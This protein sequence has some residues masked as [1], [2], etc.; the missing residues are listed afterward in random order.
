MQ[1]STI[2]T[3][4]DFAQELEGANVDVNFW[5]KAEVHLKDGSPLNLHDLPERLNQCWKTTFKLTEEDLKSTEKIV[6]TISSLFQKAMVRKNERNYITQLFAY[7]REWTSVQHCWENDDQGGQASI[8]KQRTLTVLLPQPI[9]LGS[10]TKVKIPKAWI[11]TP[12]TEALNAYFRIKQNIYHPQPLTL[13][14][15]QAF[16]SPANVRATTTLF[17]GYN[18]ATVGIYPHCT[19]AIANL[20]KILEELW[21]QFKPESVDRDSNI[22]AA[23]KII[24]RITD[25]NRQAEAEMATRN[26]LTRKLHARKVTPWGKQEI[27]YWEKRFGI[28]R[29]ENESVVQSNIPCPPD[30]IFGHALKVLILDPHK[31]ISWKADCLMNVGK[32][33]KAWHDIAKDCELWHRLLESD[34]KLESDQKV[35]R[36]YPLIEKGLS[37]GVCQVRQRYLNIFMNLQMTKQISVRF[38]TQNTAP[39]RGLD[40]L[41][42]GENQGAYT[43]PYRSIIANHRVITMWSRHVRLSHPDTSRPYINIYDPVTKETTEIR[44]L[45]NEPTKFIG[46]REGND[47]NATFFA[48]VL[49]VDM[50]DKRL[51]WQRDWT[52]KL[53]LWDSTTGECV[54]SS[55]TPNPGFKFD[56][57]SLSRDSHI[58]V[59]R[60]YFSEIEARGRFYEVW[61]VAKHQCL[62][63]FPFDIN[64]NFQG[65]A[66]HTRFLQV[67]LNLNHITGYALPYQQGDVPA[68]EIPYGPELSKMALSIINDQRFTCHYKTAD[69]A[70][71]D[72]YDMNGKLITSYRGFKFLHNYNNLLIAYE[73]NS[74]TNKIK[75]IDAESGETRHD[76]EIPE[77]T[78]YTI[79]HK[80][81]KPQ[82]MLLENR[83]VIF[84]ETLFSFQDPDA[85]FIQ[86]VDH[87]WVY[88]IETG[89]EIGD[90]A[91][92]HCV[93]PTKDQYDPST[94]IL[95]LQNFTFNDWTR[96]NLFKF[97]NLGNGSLVGQVAMHSEHAVRRGFV[98]YHF[99]DGFLVDPTRGFEDEPLLHNFAET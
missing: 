51:F 34:H 15:F 80:T 81:I 59:R 29:Q 58:V 87:L 36:C 56:D 72:L 60:S 64:T 49:E 32:V 65:F 92:G 50:S 40:L 99:R 85:D 20:P 5:G 76:I 39:L 14:T 93:M 4:S 70:C 88:D 19:L 41:T 45:P 44:S 47:E 62:G 96:E 35:T 98:K 95:M 86:G 79:T 43:H 78:H 46:P 1:I 22:A 3:I 55:L 68:F 91:I 13:K 26:W 7:F 48:D 73:D 75:I 21:F 77:A 52:E 53:N 33:C 18:V 90:H 17:G 57:K 25:L 6:N 27:E 8:W 84:K 10:R 2:N 83:L 97:L 63:V 11:N 94:Q 28:G 16:L 66:T 71:L 67:D 23:K 31:D 61:D 24:G 54:V 42:W 74:K 37:P 38:L 69:H 30:D 89:K 12:E 82:L 9:L